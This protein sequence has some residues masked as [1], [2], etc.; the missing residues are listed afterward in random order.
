MDF[1]V[2]CK[3]R[4]DDRPCTSILGGGLIGPHHH[5]I[6]PRRFHGECNRDAFHRLALGIPNMDDEPTES[7]LVIGR[8]RNRTF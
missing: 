5:V 2:A 7:E 8:I 3:M 1:D 4:L 6:F